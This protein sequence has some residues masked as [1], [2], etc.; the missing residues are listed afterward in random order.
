[1][2]VTRLQAAANKLT[3]GAGADILETYLALHKG[4]IGT[5]W[6]WV[7]IERVVAGEPEVEVMSDYG[8]VRAP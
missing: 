7:A 1:M 8:Y 4:K 5:H 6:L 3:R 2:R